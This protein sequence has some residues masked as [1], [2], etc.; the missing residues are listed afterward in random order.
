VLHIAEPSL[1]RSLAGLF[2]EPALDLLALAFPV[3]RRV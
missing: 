2:F 1:A 3:G